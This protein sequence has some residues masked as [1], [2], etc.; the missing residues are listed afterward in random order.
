MLVT[1]VKAKKKETS[2]YVRAAGDMRMT[3]VRLAGVRG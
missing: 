1:E 2:R 3:T